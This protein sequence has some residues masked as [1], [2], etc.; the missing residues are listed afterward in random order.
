MI[1]IMDLN[2]PPLPEDD[3]DSFEQH[4]EGYSALE[5]HTEH[6]NHSDHVESAVDILRRVHYFL[7]QN[8]FIFDFNFLCFVVV[9]IRQNEYNKIQCVDKGSEVCKTCYAGS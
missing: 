3:E 8:F 4:V 5:K 7:L 1:G 2:A 6:V 9:P